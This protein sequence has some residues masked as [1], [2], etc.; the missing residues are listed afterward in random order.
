MAE[1]ECHL[2]NDGIYEKIRDGLKVCI[3]GEPNVGKS[4]LLNGLCKF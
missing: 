1:M 2:K 3:I 4:S